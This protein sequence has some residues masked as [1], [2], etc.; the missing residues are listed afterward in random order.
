MA[1]ILITGANRGIGL[2]LT[3]AFLEDD[4][5]VI[6]TARDPG[7]AEELKETGVN[8]LRLDVGIKCEGCPPPA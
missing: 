6:G 3:K 1:T 2:A 8:V 5:V 4:H 7:T